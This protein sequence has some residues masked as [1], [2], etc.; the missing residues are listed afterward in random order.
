MRKIKCEM[1]D[2]RV[3]QS[4]VVLGYSQ[5]HPEGLPF[6]DRCATSFEGRILWDGVGWQVL[7]RRPGI[8]YRED[9]TIH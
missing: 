9:P 7:S 5:Y 2:H 6:C 8:G 4:E 3:P 1:C